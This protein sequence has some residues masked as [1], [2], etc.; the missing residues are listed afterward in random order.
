M[1]AENENLLLLAFIKSPWR[2]I[3]IILLLIIVS[4]YWL[5]FEQEVATSCNNV[6]ATATSSVIPVECGIRRYLQ[7]HTCC[8][9]GRLLC[10]HLIVKLHCVRPI[11]FKSV[12]I[13]PNWQTFVN[14]SRASR[15]CVRLERANDWTDQMDCLGVHI[16]RKIIN[17]C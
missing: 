16:S 17:E 13:K 8:D 3:W 1:G 4:E 15:R 6:L 2:P 5:E 9:C 14:N 11:I 12:W 7:C 10:L